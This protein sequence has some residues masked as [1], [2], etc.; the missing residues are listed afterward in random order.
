MK[1]ILELL[2]T[3]LTTN[4][5]P[6]PALLQKGLSRD[7]IINQLSL[8]TNSPPE[9]LVEWYQ[10]QNGYPWGGEKMGETFLIDYGYTPPL[11]DAIQYKKNFGN[12]PLGLIVY[13]E[14]LPIFYS[15]FGEM[16]L[17]NLDPAAEF[18][19]FLREDGL[20]TPE[21]VA[22]FKSLDQ[23]LRTAYEGFKRGIYNFENGR[24]HY[25]L[26]LQNQLFI[27][28]N[29]EISYWKNGYS[30]DS[31]DILFIDPSSGEIKRHDQE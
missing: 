5:F 30:F 29:S 16:Y 14:M 27:E 19:I 20:S 17:Y 7:E 25:D 3:F 18:K 23:L 26:L 2:W 4:N 22:A 8:I 21:P 31:S 13:K 9:E 11:E 28:L 12:D 1:E 10:W 15:G 24:L 6:Q